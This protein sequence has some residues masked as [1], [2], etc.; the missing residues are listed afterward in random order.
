MS[1]DVSVLTSAHD[2]AD[3]RLHREVAALLRAGLTVEVLGLGDP[4]GGPPGATV[5]TWRRAGLARRAVRAMVLPW[6]AR[7]SVLLTL[8]PDVAATTA[9]RRRLS[10]RVRHVADVHED[11]GSLLRDRGWARGVVAVAAGWL[12]RVAER[13]SAGADLLVVADEHLM[14]GGARLVVRNLPDATVLPDPGAPDAEPRAL[15]VGDIRRSRGLYTML[16][17]MRRAPGWTLDLVGPVSPRDRDDLD[18]V[19]EDEPEL[20][21]RVRLH[22]RMPPRRS[23]ELARGAWVG[24]LLLEDTPAFR[25]AMPSK[26]Y[27]YLACGLPVLTTPLPRPAALVEETGAG[28]VIDGPVGAAAKLRAWSEDRPSLQAVRDAAGAAAHRWDGTAEVDALAA[29]IVGLVRR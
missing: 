22:G 3:A 14:G 26:L 10:R 25:E 20:A 28:A 12:V 18:R 4:A 15:Y 29:R 1:V 7:G 9:V 23:W 8:D 21:A 27:E 6:R 11:Y 17:V 24:L 5:R 19:L 2:V 16:E 13:A